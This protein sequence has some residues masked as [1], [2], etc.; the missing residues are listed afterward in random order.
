MSPQ[1]FAFFTT[2]WEALAKIYSL[3]GLWWTGWSL[4]IWRRV[5]GL[6]LSAPIPSSPQDLEYYA[7][8]AETPKGTGTVVSPAMLSRLYFSP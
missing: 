2:F 7:L 5:F 1:V 6:K 3:M 8:K 4:G